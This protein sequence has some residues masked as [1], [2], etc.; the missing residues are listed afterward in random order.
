MFVST[1]HHRCCLALFGRQSRVAF[2]VRP[3]VDARKMFGRQHLR[4]VLANFFRLFSVISVIFR[5]NIFPSC[6]TF[7][8]VSWHD[9]HIWMHLALWESSWSWWC[10]LKH[11]EAIYQTDRCWRVGKLRNEDHIGRVP[12]DAGGVRIRLRQE[13]KRLR[14]A[15]C[16]TVF[17]HRSWCSVREVGIQPGG[18][19]YDPSTD[20]KKTQIIGQSR[21][22]NMSDIISKYIKKLRSNLI[23]YLLTSFV[24]V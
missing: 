10:S 23:F 7:K 14:F 3:E 21:H 6:S 4:F 24:I 12:R 13:L 20:G 11:I 1:K 22:L 2:M 8:F 15:A 19:K 5:L 17:V 16:C 9:W 18:A